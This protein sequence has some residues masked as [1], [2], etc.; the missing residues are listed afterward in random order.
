MAVSGQEKL[1]DIPVFSVLS[2][3]QPTSSG[4]YFDKMEAF[5]LVNKE[6]T[7]VLNI[8]ETVSEGQAIHH[9]L[10][11][12]YLNSSSSNT[13][14]APDHYIYTL[15]FFCRQEYKW[16]KTTKIPLRLRIGSLEQC[17]LLEGK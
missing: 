10:P 14:L 11:F 12:L 6:E 3:S 16:E 17:N 9:R 1:R 5:H 2:V 4:A 7:N 15:A 13:L 8:V